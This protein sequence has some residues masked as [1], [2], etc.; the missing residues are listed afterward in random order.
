MK[1]N[2]E[3]LVVTSFQ[4]NEEVISPITDP[5]DPTPATFCY[6]CPAETEQNCW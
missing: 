6:I 2:S 1:L 3:D 5:N 4:T